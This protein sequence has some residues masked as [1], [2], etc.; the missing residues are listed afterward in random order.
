LNGIINII[1]RKETV[2]NPALYI[3]P[4]SYGKEKKDFVNQINNIT[5]YAAFTKDF[6]PFHSLNHLFTLMLALSSQVGVYTCRKLLSYKI[7]Q[8]TYYKFSETNFTVQE[9]A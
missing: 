1:Q 6:H 3:L 2:R 5:K 7:P 4:G 9:Y 8:I